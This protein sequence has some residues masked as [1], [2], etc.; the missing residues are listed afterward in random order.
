LRRAEGVC[1]AWKLSRRAYRGGRRRRLRLGDR[2]GPGASWTFDVTV[3]DPAAPGDNASGVAAGMLAPVSEALFDPVSAPHLDLL[4]R[5]RDLWPAFA[6]GWRRDPAD[7]VR[8]EGDAWRGWTR[9]PRVEDLACA[10]DPT[11][12]GASSTRI[13][14]RTLAT[15][16]ASAR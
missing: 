12:D 13:G 6:R 8:V 2:P 16:G 14:G 10:D 3:F 4:R 5:A 11:T 7:G 9:S 15:P 1:P